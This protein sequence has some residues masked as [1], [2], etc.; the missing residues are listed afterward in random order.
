[1]EIAILTGEPSGDL[2]GASLARA[3]RELDPEV[4]LWGLGSRTMAEA[5]V[6]LLADSASWSAIGI[7]AS[8]PKIPLLALKIAPKLRKTLAHRRPEI[9]VFI[10]FGAFNV[11]MARYCQQIGLKTLYYIPPGCWR[12]ATA[13]REDI[14]HLVHGIAL[15]F[16][17]GQERYR[18]GKARVFYVGHPLLDR[19]SPSTTR[20]AFAK[21][22]GLDPHAPL[23]GLL[24][25]SRL[26]EVNNLLPTL[27]EAIP[28]IA[29][30]VPKAQFAVAVAPTLSLEY[31]QNLIR[32]H[33]IAHHYTAERRPD[34][35]QERAHRSK[36]LPNALPQPAL[37]TQG[38]ALIGSPKLSQKEWRPQVAMPASPPLVLTQGSTYDL[39]AHA[40][41]LLVCSGT[42]TLEA[43]VLQ[44]PMIVLYR[45]SK[46][47]E[48][49]YRLRRM[50]KKV[51]EIKYIALPNILADRSI[52]PELIQQ[53]ATPQ[54]IA[55]RAVN[56]L[57]DLCARKQMRQALLDV[58]NL[59][60]EPGASARTARIA[61]ALACNINDALPS[62]DTEIG[63]H[64]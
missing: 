9:V 35:V 54:T 17:W 42:A 57:T 31:V 51:Q 28:L 29:R 43:A 60:G 56:L 55:E 27:L 26:H 4:K 24:P 23:I 41:L 18:Q 13:L 11:R 63:F 25:G 49:E 34:N 39:M 14:A 22:L 38:G 12:R 52:V 19:V 16:P 33:P 47:M 50:D 1:M 3:L 40:D 5:G 20:D 15:P 53:Q 30:E 37:A 6:E 64:A 48:L 32:K 36:S 45:V 7:V 46:W 8:L 10:D 2:A 58:R 61:L 21:S 44:T 59:L 62:E